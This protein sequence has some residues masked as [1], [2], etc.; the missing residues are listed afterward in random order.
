MPGPNFDTRNSGNAYHKIVEDLAERPDAA[1]LK[2]DEAI[3]T[4]DDHVDIT[5]PKYNDREAQLIETELA[6]ADGTAETLP[7]DDLEEEETAFSIEEPNVPN[8]Y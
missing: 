3:G 4:L 2:Q 8:P 1:Q 7:S 6:Q 5:D